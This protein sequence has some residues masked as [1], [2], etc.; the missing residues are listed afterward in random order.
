MKMG[1]WLAVVLVGGLAVYVAWKFVER[2]RFLR[3]LSVERV[4]P[5]ELL[6]KLDSKEPPLLIDLRHSLELQDGIRK[7]PRALHIPP[8]EIESRIGEIPPG[9][10]V[11]LY[12]T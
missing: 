4:T 11:V 2:R 6:R 12:C 7:L 1:G 5:D 3:G 10:E 8:E 9:R